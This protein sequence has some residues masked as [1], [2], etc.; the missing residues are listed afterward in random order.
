MEMEKHRQEARLNKPT[1]AI[2]FKQ[3]MTGGAKKPIDAKHSDC[4][5][6][7]ED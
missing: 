2:S 3:W 6:C 1:N 5:C 7:E 4:D